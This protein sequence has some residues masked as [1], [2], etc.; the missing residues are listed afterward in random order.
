[1]GQRISQC[2]AQH[3][4]VAQECLAL[5]GEYFSWLATF[6]AAQLAAAGKDPLAPEQRRFHSVGMVITP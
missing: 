6:E 5:G 1:M 3:M 2:M 4:G